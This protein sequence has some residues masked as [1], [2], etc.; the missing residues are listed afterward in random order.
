MKKCL[1]VSFGKSRFFNSH[2]FNTDTRVPLKFQR[3]AYI[4]PT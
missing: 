1:S 4:A 3:E 2:S